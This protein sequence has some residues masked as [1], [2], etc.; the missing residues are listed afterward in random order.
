RQS[1]QPSG[2][3]QMWRRKLAKEW[4]LTDVLV[5]ALI[6]RRRTIRA[7]PSLQKRNAA[8]YD[9]NQREQKESRFS[10]ATTAIQNEAGVAFGRTRHRYSGVPYSRLGTQCRDPAVG[11]IKDG[12]ELPHPRPGSPSRVQA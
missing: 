2:R 6:N 9:S 8:E 7:K 1:R 4:T 5:C 10:S 11:R 12:E 3:G